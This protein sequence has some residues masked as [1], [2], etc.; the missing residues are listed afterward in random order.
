M[1]LQLHSDCEPIGSRFDNAVFATVCKASFLTSHKACNT[2]SVQTVESNVDNMN[3]SSICKPV[4]SDAAPAYPV[5][6]PEAFI[7][8]ASDATH[9]HAIELSNTMHRL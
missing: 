4:V 1:C 6:K 7:S 2:R 9:A 3:A 8:R 5:A